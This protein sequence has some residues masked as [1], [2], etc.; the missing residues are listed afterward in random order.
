MHRVINTFTQT[1]WR[2]ATAKDGCATIGW[3]A[4][5]S[6][7]VMLVD[8]EWEEGSLNGFLWL[9]REKDQRNEKFTLV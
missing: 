8:G 7:F 3:A 9:G 2:K 4:A 1:Q 6:G 5:K